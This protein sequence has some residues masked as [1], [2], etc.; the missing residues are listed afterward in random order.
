MHKTDNKFTLH[1][2]T[3][4]LE[5]QYKVILVHVLLSEDVKISMQNEGKRGRTKQTVQNYAR[6]YTRMCVNVSETTSA[7]SLVPWFNFSFTHH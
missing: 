5:Y 1:P 4:F 3:R 2:I 7:R 6:E